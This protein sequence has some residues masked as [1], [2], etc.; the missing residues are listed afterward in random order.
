MNSYH[1]DQSE[2]AGDLY[3]WVFDDHPLGYFILDNQL[4]I[5]RVNHSFAHLLEYSVKDLIGKDLGKFV[6]SNSYERQ[7]DLGEKLHSGEINNLDL[8]GVYVARS[9]QHIFCRTLIKAVFTSE[10]ELKYCVATVI[11]KQEAKANEL[12]LQ[13]SQDLW[14]SV[15]NNASFGIAII[16]PAIMKFVEANQSFIETL[17]YSLP[18]LCQLSP[19][20]ISP[21]LQPD[22][23]SSQIKGAKLIRDAMQGIN[24]LFSWTHKTKKGQ[25]RFFT[26]RLDQFKLQEKELMLALAEDITD[27]KLQESSLKTSEN[28]YKQLY[29]S[30]PLMFFTIDPAGSIL[31]ANQSVVEQLGFEESELINSDVMALLHPEDRTSFTHRLESFISGQED[32]SNPHL[33]KVSKSG[34]I[35]WVRE[36]IKWVDWERKRAIFLACENVTEKIIAERLKVQT[37]K[38]Y[39]SIFENSFL[40]I[41]INDA[42]GQV[43][44]ANPALCN[45]LGYSEQDLRG[46]NFLDLTAPDDRNS[47]EKFT[48][49]FRL[50]KKA[51]TIEKKY[52]RKDGTFLHA[53]TLGKLLS[54]DEPEG[55]SLIMIWDI[56]D[57]KRYLEQKVELLQ[58]NQLINL[59]NQELTNYTLFLAQKRELLSQMSSALTEMI[60]EPTDHLPAKI[61][62]LI[63]R[64]NQNI[65][66]ENTWL[67]FLKHFQE[68]NPNFLKNLQSEHPQL[69]NSELRHCAYILLSM[70][71]IEVANL[72]HVTTKAV[73]IARYRIK[74][75]LGL[76]NRHDKLSEFLIKYI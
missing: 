60:N 24:P 31:A 56:Y 69:T 13:Q 76:S 67:D 57:E 30:N 1:S 74:K 18:E 34:Q 54:D 7:R 23:E 59:K 17:G 64:V 62:R 45:M 75:K 28:R 68:V 47:S 14:K 3:Q 72:L 35:I 41:A 46:K 73:E 50:M 39:Q 8:E 65:D 71:N 42:A 51:I 29:D 49:E 58:K 53:R 44:M 55:Q 22:G 63:A 61:K 37:E 43:V 4:R 25:D 33:R 21:E 36:I 2:Q 5:V 38:K 10:G 16:D 19:M 40:G 20:D 66:G 32:E 15:C 48:R 27:Q 70:S 52:V 12:N 9:G 26:I 6:E 11:D